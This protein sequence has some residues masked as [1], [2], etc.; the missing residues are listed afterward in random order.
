MRRPADDNWL[1]DPIIISDT[2]GASEGKEVCSFAAYC[3]SSSCDKFGKGK[4]ED[5][6]LEWCC[7]QGVDFV[8]DGGLRFADP[9]TVV[10]MTGTK[11][12][13]LRRGKVCFSFIS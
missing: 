7:C 10:D 11:P 3:H 4:I 8:V 1:L 13:L 12:L 2:Y 9:S 6:I 5:A